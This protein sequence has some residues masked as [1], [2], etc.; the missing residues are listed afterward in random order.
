M[1]FAT[2]PRQLAAYKR[3]TK[4]VGTKEIVGPEDN[5]K[6]VEWFKQVGHGW[7]RDDETAWCAAFVGAMLELSGIVSTRGLNARSYVEWGE[8]VKEPRPGD[9]V[10]FWRGSPDSWKGHVGF[11]VSQ[12]R[13]HI[14]VL[15]GNQANSVSFAN[16][17]TASLLSIRRARSTVEPSAFAGII[18]LIMKI[19][20]SW[21]G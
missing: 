15:G 4:E 6:I 14:K 12:D 11:F 20:S 3:A 21:K 17:S 2:D 1:T 8:E 13:K 7:V 10:V 16:Y 9:I 5:P 19:F 18:A